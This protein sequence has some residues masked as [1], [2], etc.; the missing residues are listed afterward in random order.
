MAKAAGFDEHVCQGRQTRNPTPQ[1]PR[2]RPAARVQAAKSN[3][4]SVSVSL[5]R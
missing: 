5:R 2:P 3:F 4:L 1:T